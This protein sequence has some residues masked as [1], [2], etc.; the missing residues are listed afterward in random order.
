LVLTTLVA[1]VGQHLVVELL[2]V[3]VLEAAEQE[4]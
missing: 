2:V 3:V 1:V 4:A